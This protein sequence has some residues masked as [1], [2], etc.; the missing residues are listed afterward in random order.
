MPHVLRSLY[1]LTSR[2]LLIAA[3]AIGAGSALQGCP[4]R[5]SP[6]PSLPASSHCTRRS[7]SCQV[8]PHEAQESPYVC[9]DEGRWTRIGNLSCAAV[10]G[11]CIVTRT[12]H[13]AES[14]PLADAGLSVDSGAAGDAR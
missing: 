8:A 5:F 4:Q 7:F 10:G 12:A 14:V 3:L 2:L 6:I 9:D 11:H 13:C 1:I